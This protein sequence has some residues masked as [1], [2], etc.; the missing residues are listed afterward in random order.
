[1]KSLFSFNV[2]ITIF[3]SAFLVGLKMLNL[4][5]YFG[6]LNEKFCFARQT[7]LLLYKYRGCSKGFSTV[8]RNE[9]RVKLCIENKG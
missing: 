1:M 9:K 5:I 3:F 7:F 6:E 4:T 2:K 8:F